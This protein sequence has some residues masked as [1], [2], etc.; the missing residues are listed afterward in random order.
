MTLT[1]HPKSLRPRL[2]ILKI[3]FANPSMIS[4]TVI[5][6]SLVIELKRPEIFFSPALGKSIVVNQR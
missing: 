3:D 1:W 6:D 5:E 2:L 4:P